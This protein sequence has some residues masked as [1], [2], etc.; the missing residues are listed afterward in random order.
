VIVQKQKEKSNSSTL[1]STS[2]TSLT[3]GAT[4]DSLAETSHLQELIS[5][6]PSKL[7]KEEQGRTF[8]KNIFIKIKICLFTPPRN[9][10]FKITFDLSG[11][12]FILID[13]Y[14]R[15]QKN[16]KT[17]MACT[18]EINESYIRTFRMGSQYCCGCF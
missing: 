8:Y 16:A 1:S 2:S 18:L 12:L 13:S 9:P 14:K 6:I 11:F 3:L 15:T 10:H 17:R 7:A 5:E 4:M